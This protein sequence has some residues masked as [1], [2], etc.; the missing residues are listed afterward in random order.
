MINLTDQILNVI[1]NRQGKFTAVDIA[2]EIGYPLNETAYFPSCRNVRVILTKLCKEGLLY[3]WIT[4]NGLSPTSIG[5]TSTYT[6]N[7]LRRDSDL[8]SILLNHSN[9]KL[10]GYRIK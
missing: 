3:Q 4:G 10:I 6:V 5:N 7:Y 8:A 9:R 2:E 1:S